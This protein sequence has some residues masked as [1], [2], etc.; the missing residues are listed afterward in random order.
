MVYVAGLPDHKIKDEQLV[1]HLVGLI[2]K[3]AAEIDAERAE[4]EAIRPVPAF[5]AG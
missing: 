2:E 4:A 1:D 3:K 5:A